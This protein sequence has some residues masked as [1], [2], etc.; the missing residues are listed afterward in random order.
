MDHEHPEYKAFS[1]MTMDKENELELHEYRQQQSYDQSS[2]RLGSHFTPVSG[3]C[4]ETNYEQQ[5]EMN[6][7]DD[8]RSTISSTSAKSVDTSSPRKRKP[9]VNYRSEI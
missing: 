6:Y 9:K 5:N 8:S 4:H 2:V 3:K 1:T 7:N